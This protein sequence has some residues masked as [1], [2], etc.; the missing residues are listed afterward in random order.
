[1][2]KT[3]PLDAVAE[4]AV[5]QVARATSDAEPTRGEPDDA[6]ER[7]LRAT[8]HELIDLH[9]LLEV[10]TSR[11]STKEPYRRHQPAMT[12]FVPLIERGR[13]NGVLRS[14]LPVSWHLAML[15]AIVHAA[16]A[17]VRSGRITEAEVEPAIL[18]TVTGSARRNRSVRGK[19][20]FGYRN[21]ADA[22]C[23]ARPI[24]QRQ[25][26]AATPRASRASAR[27]A[28]S[29]PSSNAA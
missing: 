8:R 3:E 7:V 18:S 24:A 29:C 23:L 2:S 12:L 10:D 27:S 5:A 21:R 6:L 14:D 28:V 22:A 26:R 4:H 16:C 19:H 11:L 13:K 1:M 20:P 17:E 15:R 25:P 9:A